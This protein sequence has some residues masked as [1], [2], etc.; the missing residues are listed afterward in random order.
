M[1]N[2][3]RDF[4][5]DDELAII[6]I[7]SFPSL[8][9]KHKNAI[10]TS[11]EKPSGVFKNPEPAVKYLKANLGEAAANTFLHSLSGDAYT[12]F[13]LDLLKEKGVT[14]ITYLSKKYPESLLPLPLRPLILYCKG[15]L[16]LLDQEPKIAVVGSRK[17][18]P[19]VL[20]KCESICRDLAESGAVIVTGSAVGGDRSALLGSLESGNVISVLAHGL[21]YVYPQSNRELI[22]KVAEKGL[23]ISEYS[24]EVQSAP[25]RFPMRNRIIAGLGQAT[26]IVSGNMQSG[27]RY[28]AKFSEAYSR[29]MYAFPYSIG[30]SSGEICNLLIKLNKASLVE[31]TEDIA[32]GENITLNA[33]SEVELEGDEAIIYSVL[34]G[35]CAVNE[36]CEKT[37]KK[38]HELL[39][40]LSML[41][42]KGLVARGKASGTFVPIKKR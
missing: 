17:T 5:T 31:D 40:V 7:D 10:I 6:I 37:G 27:T 3:N 8:E 9:Y 38:V 41:E 21:D 15:N 25:W 24:P 33:E 34:E 16:S 30:E 2:F 26:F 28:T 29:R 19:F 35:E 23:I 32:L 1:E 20:K 11:Y 18:L 42:I 12:K 14:A 22:E 39:S 13:V 4:Y 36:L